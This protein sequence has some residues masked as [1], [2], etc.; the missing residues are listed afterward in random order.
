MM[1]SLQF[2]YEPSHPYAPIHEIVEGRNK[3]IKEFYWRL[4]F[5]D[6]EEPQDLNVRDTLMGSRRPWTTLSSLVGKQ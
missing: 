3:R 5:G 4:W 1:P 2:K 6:D